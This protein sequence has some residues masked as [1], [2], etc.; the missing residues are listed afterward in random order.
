[1][2]S[3]RRRDV[4][5]GLGSAIGA[6][7]LGPA[8]AQSAIDLKPEFAEVFHDAKTEGQFAAKIGDRFVMTD[9]GRARTGHLPGSTF[10]IPHALIALETGVVADVDKE[11][12]RWDGVVREIEPWNRDH[13]LR[14]AM[15]YS[16]VPAFQQIANRIGAERMKQF[17]DAFDYGNRDI[18]GAL[19]RFWL[20]GALRISA[21]EQIEFL[22][23]FHSGELPVSKRSLTLVKDILPVEKTEDATIH[24]KTGAIGREG[25]P[26]FGWLVG[27][28]ER[29]EAVTFFA[30]SMDIHGEPHLAQRIALTRA[31]LK[32][33]GR[34]G[35]S[36]IRRSGYRFAA[37]CATEIALTAG[38][39]TSGSRSGRSVGASP[40]SRL[41]CRLS[42]LCKHCLPPP[43]RRPRRPCCS[44][45]R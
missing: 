9:E 8:R 25:K 33:A 14:T 37:D 27:Y 12:I 22:Q 38:R 35:K 36:A 11:V 24:F 40:D 21:L 39:L 6:L 43:A 15:Q 30:M 10:K 1:M 7:A 2:L 23:R 26:S 13:T 41:R 29:G 4:L 28:A 42:P 18:G 16:V 34:S 3:P 17:V 45:A 31:L 20:D 19:D 32:R 5:F 44:R